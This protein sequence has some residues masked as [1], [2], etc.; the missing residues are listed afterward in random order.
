MKQYV[1]SQLQYAGLPETA[2]LRTLIDTKRRRDWPY[3]PVDEGDVLFQ[4]ARQ[5]PAGEG[6]EIGFATGSTAL[7]MLHALDKGHLTSIDFRQ[8]DHDYAGV[9]LVRD[10]GMA[11]RHTLIEENSIAALPRLLA[12]GRRFDIVFLDGWK[13]FD[14][15][16]VDSFYCAKLLKVGGYLVFDD[17]R[18]PAVRKCAALLERYYQFKGIDTYSMCGGIRQRMWHLASTRSLL[19]PYLAFRKTC[20]IETTAAGSQFDYWRSF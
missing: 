14:H 7:F 1:K 3:A 10:S 4:L 19:P 12:E 8:F 17:A 2:Q 20:E 18:M 5:T 15:V 11:D 16:W 9:A 13:T 6:L